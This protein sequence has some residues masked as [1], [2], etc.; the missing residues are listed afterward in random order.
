MDMADVQETKVGTS[1][2]DIIHFLRLISNEMHLMS[3]DIHK[4]FNELMGEMKEQNA[5]LRSELKQIT[6]IVMILLKK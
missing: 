5:S 4:H 1:K 6:N 3:N 2:D